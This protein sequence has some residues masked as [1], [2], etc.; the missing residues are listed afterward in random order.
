MGYSLIILRFWGKDGHQ[1]EDAIRNRIINSLPDGVESIVVQIHE[2]HIESDNAV[3]VFSVTYHDSAWDSGD[4]DVCLYD[5]IDQEQ[6]DI[7]YDLLYET[8][9]DNE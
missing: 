6:R 5:M 9:D 3:A 7:D 4:L 2:I 8:P 1:T